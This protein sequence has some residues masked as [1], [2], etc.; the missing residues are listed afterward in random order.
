MAPHII[1]F[2][3]VITATSIQNIR[4]LDEGLRQTTAI[5][6]KQNDKG[7]AGINN[8][9]QFIQTAYTAAYT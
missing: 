2:Y 8:S 5:P 1:Q 7:P 4:Q 9:H 3:K 6:N